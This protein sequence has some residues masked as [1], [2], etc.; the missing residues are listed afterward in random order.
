MSEPTDG[1]FRY[2]VESLERRVLRLEDLE[3]AVVRSQVIDTR[4][5]IQN[6]TKAVDGI[7]KIL[8]TFLVAWSGIGITVVVALFTKTG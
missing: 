7:R 6:L 1:G 2:R 5:D 8:I 4:E 3:P